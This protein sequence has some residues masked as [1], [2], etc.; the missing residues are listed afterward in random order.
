MW[1][2]AARKASP[3]DANQPTRLT[4][5]CKVYLYIRTILKEDPATIDTPFGKL[6]KSAADWFKGV[7]ESE[8][9]MFERAL[10][11]YRA[12]NVSV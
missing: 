4:V 12:Q 8:S 7:D 6:R 9:G 1:T 10:S 3:L 5:L 11:A 2:A